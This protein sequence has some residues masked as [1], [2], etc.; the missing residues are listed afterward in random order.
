[1]FEPGVFAFEAAEGGAVTVS[2]FG[3]NV[4]FVGGWGGEGWRKMHGWNEVKGV[5]GWGLKIR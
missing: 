3:I 5:K 2:E 1:M 4:V